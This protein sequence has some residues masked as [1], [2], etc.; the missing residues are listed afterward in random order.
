M[1]SYSVVRGYRRGAR[2]AWRMLSSDFRPRKLIS[3]DQAVCHAHLP[4]V[5][6]SSQATLKGNV[7]NILKMFKIFNSKNV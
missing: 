2:L 4:L 1:A 6:W 7:K 3:I 5:D